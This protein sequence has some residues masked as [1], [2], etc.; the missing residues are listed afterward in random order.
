M[1]KLIFACMLSMLVSTPSIGQSINEKLSSPTETPSVI[2]IKD[3]CNR[4]R[5]LSYS[6]GEHVKLAYVYLH[7]ETYIGWRPVC[8]SCSYKEEVIEAANALKNVVNLRFPDVEI[9][10]KFQQIYQPN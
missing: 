3:Q 4:I 5:Y 1:K 2:C 9:G 7:G 6:Y 10:H 8:L